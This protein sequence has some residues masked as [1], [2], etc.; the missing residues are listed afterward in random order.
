[1]LIVLRYVN[2]ALGIKERLVKFVY[3]Q[4]GITA[5]AISTYLKTELKSLG[6]DAMARLT[7]EWV[8]WQGDTLVQPNYFSMS[9]PKLFCKSSFEH[10]YC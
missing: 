10:L 6:L 3:C 4:D 8:T 2:E 5:E 7:M 9:I 1:M